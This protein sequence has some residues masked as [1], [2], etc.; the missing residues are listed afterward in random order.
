MTDLD[1]LMHMLPLMY[2]LWIGIHFIISD[3]QIAA[4]VQTMIP[5]H[6]LLFKICICLA[7]LKESVKTVRDSPVEY[8]YNTI[9]TEPGIP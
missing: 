5:L 4:K 2:A 3:V 7:D 8:L 6:I 1:L 9:Y